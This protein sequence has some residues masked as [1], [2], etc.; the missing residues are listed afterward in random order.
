MSSPISSLAP[1]VELWKTMQLEFCAAYPGDAAFWCTEQTNSALLATAAWKTRGMG[2]VEYPEQRWI[3]DDPCNGRVDLWLRCS[4]PGSAAFIVEAKF[5]LLLGGTRGP[6]ERVQD[7]LD[8][9]VAAVKTCVPQTGEQ[10][11]GVLYVVPKL[12]DLSQFAEL[13]AAIQGV[14]AD[15]REFVDA[16]EYRLRWPP[17]GNSFSVFPGVYLLARRVP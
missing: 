1:I 6:A 16:R 4:G 3:D 7:N 9:A 17:T 10:R 12:Q 14:P 5:H 8:A 13:D 2:I 15:L 11:V